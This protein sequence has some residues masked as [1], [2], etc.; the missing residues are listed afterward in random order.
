M[1]TRKKKEAEVIVEVKKPTPITRN[2]ILVD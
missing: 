2:T 1:A